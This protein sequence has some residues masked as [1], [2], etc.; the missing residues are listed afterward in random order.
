MNAQKMKGYNKRE[1]VRTDFMNFKCFNDI[2]YK[3]PTD[4]IKV[5]VIIVLNTTDKP[6]I[7]YLEFSGKFTLMT[8]RQYTDTNVSIFLRKY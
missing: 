4:F 3:F 6:W 7:N 5:L 8:R 1:K 2:L